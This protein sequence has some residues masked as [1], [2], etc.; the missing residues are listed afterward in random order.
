VNDVKVQ[1]R[2]DGS[3]RDD[4]SIA[5]LLVAARRTVERL[6]NRS[7]LPQ[8]W[9]LS[10]QRFP[11][12]RI[13][14]PRAPLIGVDWVQWTGIAESQSIV[15]SG[16]YDVNTSGDPGSVVLQFARI[17]PP[18]P[19]S[20]S[21]PVVVQ[22]RAGYPYFS[23]HVNVDSTGT[24]LT[25]SDSSSFSTSWPIY[26]PII[27][28]GISSTVLSVQS[29]TQLTLLSPCSFANG[30]NVRWSLNLVPAELKL[31][32]AMLATHWYGPGRT[33][34]VVGRGV[35]SADISLTVKQLITPYRV[36]V[37]GFRQQSSGFGF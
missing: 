30:T 1:A 9:Q 22:F 33:P 4:V 19:L 25:I 31:A 32:I 3:S 21:K 34:V 18:D 16:L 13:I 6:T 7:L 10:L 29:T 27:L 14:L 37:M 23:G 15:D 12:D 5:G 20:P 17:W 2:V 35:T 28:N 24:V 36:N 26:S 11:R 8:T